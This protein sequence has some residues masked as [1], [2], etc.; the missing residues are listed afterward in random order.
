[1][2]HREP[3]ASVGTPNAEA[4]PL[5]LYPSVVCPR[6]DLKPTPESTSR[7]R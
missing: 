4:L 6:R 1:V 2:P 5:L 3:S 7:A